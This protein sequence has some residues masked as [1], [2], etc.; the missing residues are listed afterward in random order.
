MNIVICASIE[1]TPKIQENADLLIHRGHQ[2][3]IPFTSEIVA[4]QPTVIHGDIGHI[5]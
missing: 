2:V 1:F 3:Q 4:M 5:V